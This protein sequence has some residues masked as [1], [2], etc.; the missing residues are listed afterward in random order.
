MKNSSAGTVR[1]P[2]APAIVIV[3]LIAT[4]SGGKWFVG[5]LRQT[6]PPIV[7]RLRTWTSAISEATRAMIGRARLHDIDVRLSASERPR[8]RAR[9]EQPNGLVNGPGPCVLHRGEEHAR[10]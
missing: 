9:P 4:I 5:S 2:S 8:V 3:A 6:L 7:P 1:V 10:I